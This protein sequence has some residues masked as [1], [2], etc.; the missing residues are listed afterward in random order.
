MAVGNVANLTVAQANAILAS[1]A[2]N[3]RQFYE[4]ITRKRTQYTQNAAV[5]TALFP[6][7]GDQAI[8]QAFVADLGRLQTV[9]ENGVP[10]AHDIAGN[11]SNITGIQ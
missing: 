6:A 4:W 2:A 1:D 7:A 11:L 10:T 8:F 9:F 3:L 5:L